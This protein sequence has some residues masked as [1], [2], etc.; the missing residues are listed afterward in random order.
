MQSEIAGLSL[1]P[2]YPVCLPDQIHTVGARRKGSA[3][4]FRIPILFPSNPQG[5]KSLGA[6]V[7][8]GK[9]ILDCQ[10]TSMSADGRLIRFGVFDVDLQSAELRKQGLRI[11]LREQPF[12]ILSLLLE[13]PG[14]LVS[15]DA[16]D[17]LARRHILPG[18]PLLADAARFRI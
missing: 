1:E 13:R 3:C 10:G 2:P 14:H 6:L 11:K 17:A 8:S 16:K 9:A 4:D 12:Q 7:L 15:R 18:F 5:N